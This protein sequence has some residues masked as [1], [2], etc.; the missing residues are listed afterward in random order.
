ME[1]KVL[2]WNWFSLFLHT[3]CLY[4]FLGSEYQK[5]G[6][7]SSQSNTSACLIDFWQVFLSSMLLIQNKH[8][9][10][11]IIIR[12][13]PFIYLCVL[14]YNA[15][16]CFVTHMLNVIFSYVVCHMLLFLLFIWLQWGFT[17]Q[18]VTHFYSQYTNIYLSLCIKAAIC[19]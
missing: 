16:S 14:E 8:F 17:E 3:A 15:T 4:L 12:K 11:S 1:L 2:Q 9:N 10:M 13:L 19:T 18:N 7:A 6:S 5:P